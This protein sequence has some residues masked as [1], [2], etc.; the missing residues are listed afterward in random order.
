[1]LSGSCQG[2]GCARRND[3]GPQ[4]ARDPTFIDALVNGEVA[5]KAVI[6]VFRVDAV[7]TALEEPF[8]SVL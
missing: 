8:G 5:P 3:G 1:M 4:R 2:V 6:S 7:Q